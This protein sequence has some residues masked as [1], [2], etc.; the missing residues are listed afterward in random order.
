MK[1]LEITPIKDKK[2][3]VLIIEKE[4]NEPFWLT[5]PPSISS[6]KLIQPLLNPSIGFYRFLENLT[7]EVKPAF[8]NDILKS[9]DKLSRQKHDDESL[10]KEYLVAYGQCLQ[11]EL[12]EQER[13]AAFPVREN[14]IV[15]DILE[16]AKG[17]YPKKEI[18]CVHLSSPEHVEGIKNL[19]ESLDVR[20]ETLRLSK[21]IVTTQVETPLTD[22]LTD[23]LQS[24]QIQVKPVVRKT[25]EE[26]PY[27]LFYLDTDEKASPFDICMAYDAGYDAV[28]PY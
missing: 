20:V 28:I 7:K 13:E 16:H 9:L 18:T 2:I 12:E 17:I 8:V 24:M 5:E 15:M 14:W 6:S 1:T 27:L 4:Y 26:I 11:L 3:V 21:K 22:N 23:F 10:E 25:S 19:L